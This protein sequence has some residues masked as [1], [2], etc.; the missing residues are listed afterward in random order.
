MNIKRV[1]A[2]AVMILLAGV[3]VI[4]YLLPGTNTKVANLDN[5]VVND[6]VQSLAEKW[7]SLDV[8]ELP[9][10]QYKL[11]YAVIDN[12][13]KLIKATR[14]GLSEDINSAIKNWDTIID[15]KQN[16]ILLGKLIIYNNTSDL[17]KHYR[18]NLI[19]LFIVITVFIALFFILYAVY[20]DRYIFRPFRKLQDFAR[21]VA[22]GN[23]D[24]PLKMDKGNIFGAFTESFD[25]MRH[26]LAKARENERIA[27]QSKKELVASLSHDI[28]T[29]VASI[30]AV[31]EIMIVKSKDEETKRQLEVINSKADQINTLITNMFTATLE[32]LQ[33]L[34]VTV[35][36]ES[37]T[38]LYEMLKNTDYNNRVA[39]N[40]IPECIVLADKMRLLQ[41]IDNIISNSYKYAGT[42]IGVS[43]SI[44]EQYLEMEFKD[45]GSG[46]SHDEI[47]LLFNKF[48]RAKNSAGKSGTGLGL[49][50]SKYL[51]K[52]M[53]GDIDCRNTNDGFSVIIKLLI[54]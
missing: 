23:L 48:Y 3:S 32:E 27:N 19:V 15:I 24:I 35:T 10:T 11:D 20:A 34:K 5:V 38:V 8:E 13:G 30:K 54:A 42:S 33:E 47:P 44:K 6:I 18:N 50:I 28:K 29:P 46:V 2:L 7:E 39:I 22:E 31:S 53:S 12:N 51:M 52:K 1:A 9:G 25:L 37:S 17:W 36:E 21:H 43:A 16:N 26:E 41:V 40:S 49:Y 14:R 45:Y 4:L